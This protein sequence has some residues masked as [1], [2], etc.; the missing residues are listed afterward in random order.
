[1]DRRRACEETARRASAASQSPP[2][3]HLQRKAR[4]KVRAFFRIKPSD[5]GIDN[6]AR[7][8]GL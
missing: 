6:K 4:T 1:M 2:H 3:R 5:R 8:P 7:S